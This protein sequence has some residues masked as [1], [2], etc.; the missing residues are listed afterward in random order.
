MPEV[1]I[2]PDNLNNEFEDGDDDFYVEA[3]HF[4]SFSKESKD[5]KKGKI[6]FRENI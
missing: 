6:I 5:N 4:Q 2:L 3:C 1:S